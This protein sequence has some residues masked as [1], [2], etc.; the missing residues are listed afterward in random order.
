MIT[1]FKTLCQPIFLLILGVTLSFT[2][3]Q[4]DL[5]NERNLEVEAHTFDLK[6][7]TLEAVYDIPKGLLSETESERLYQ[8]LLESLSAEEEVQLAE[9]MQVYTAQSAQEDLPI[10]LRN[11]SESIIH[12]IGQNDG[13]GRSV[14]KDGIYLYVGV[15]G[16][17]QVHIYAKNGSNYS[18]VHTLTPSNGAVGFG[19]TV[20][21]SGDWLAIGGSGQVYMYKRKRT[22]WTLQHI[23]TPSPSFSLLFGNDIAMSGNQ[24]AI[25]GHLPENS[26]VTYIAV[27]ELTGFGWAWQEV[28]V[29]GDG[30]T[31]FWDIDITHNR[32]VGNGGFLPSGPIFNPGVYVFEKSGGSW[33]FSTTIPFPPNNQLLRAIAIDNNTVVANTAF[34]FFASSNSSFV[35]TNTGG[36]WSHTGT[37]SQPLPIS[38]AQTRWV[39]IQ[40]S[41]AVVTMP[42]NFGDPTDAVHVFEQSGGSWN[43]TETLTPS[44][45]GA[46][47]LFGEGILLYGSEIIAGSPGSF[48]PV[49]STSAAGSVFIYE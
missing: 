29:L 3:C 11:S 5:T 28:A 39:D 19:G 36:G 38:F 31:H 49:S 20:S 15:P 14:A 25:T 46:N 27:Y 23:I 7:I 12:G 32:I 34:T 48:D 16:L 30:N 17:S 2:S 41:K 42:T 35:F 22:F 43:L 26:S 40:G 9:M 1:F 33:S 6:A 37:L 4:K 10:S 21:A 18:L 13:Y 8:N 47:L 45:G 44:T 24:M